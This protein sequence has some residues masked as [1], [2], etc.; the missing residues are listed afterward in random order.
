MITGVAGG[1]G[2][3]LAL[4]F[5]DDGYHVIGLDVKPEH[6]L[7]VDLKNSLKDYIQFDLR[8]IDEI[9]NTI[10]QIFLKHTH[11]E[12]LI[13]NAGILNFKLLHEYEVKEIQDMFSVNLTSAAVFVKVFLPYMV[14]QKFGR[15]INVSSTS[16][17][18]GE[19]KFGVYSPTK[20]GL[21]MLSESIGK[22]IENKL[23]GDIT[24]N[25]INPNRINTPEYTKENPEIN[26]AKL[27]SSKTVYRKIIRII[28]SK[29]NGAAFPIFSFGLRVKYTF[30]FIRKLF[31]S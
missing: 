14:R 8:K 1:L 17:F 3:L 5:A 20:S 25:S 26:P 24:I 23:E 27:I 11:I 28:D 22:L 15:I 10:H 30:N 18:Q 29:V 9:E 31:F 12:L 7:D 13:N 4:H 21:M 2:R 6:S 16:A 19:D